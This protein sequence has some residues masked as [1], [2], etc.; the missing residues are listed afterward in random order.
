MTPLCVSAKCRKD[1]PRMWRAYCCSSEWA[2]A[3]EFAARFHG[4][5]LAEHHHVRL[6][7]VPVR[8]QRAPGAPASGLDLRPSRAGAARPFAP[9]SPHDDAHRPI[10]PAVDERQRCGLENSAAARNRS[11]YRAS[12][13]QSTIRSCKTPFKMTR[14]AIPRSP[15]LHHASTSGP[16]LAPHD[17]AMIERSG[18]HLVGD[19]ENIVLLADLMRLAEVALVGD[20]HASFALQPQ[21]QQTSLHAH[22]A[23]SITKPLPARCTRPKLRMALRPQHEK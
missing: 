5:H 16:K 13:F 1:Q 2:G 23:H 9:R 10:H 22:N 6:D 20:K 8:A 15:M 21:Q 11:A 18:E 12:R 19:E 3:R 14:Q 7:A 4:P 17:R